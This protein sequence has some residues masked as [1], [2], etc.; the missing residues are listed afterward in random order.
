V[1]STGTGKSTL[2][3]FCTGEPVDTSNKSDECTKEIQAVK[4]ETGLVWVDTVGFDGTDTNRTDEEAFQEILQ[5]LQ[6]QNISGVAAVIWTV[7]PEIRETGSLQKQANL[8]DKFKE[9]GA[10]SNVIIVVKNTRGNIE[11][12]AAGA[13]AACNNENVKTIGYSLLD[14]LKDNEKVFW[15]KQT[16]EDRTN[17][18]ILTQVEAKLLIKNTLKTLPPSKQVVFSNHKCESCG[19]VGDPRL[20]P[21]SCHT[22]R[23]AVHPAASVPEHRGSTTLIHPAARARRHT[24]GVDF[25][26]S[27]SKSRF[28]GGS[29]SQGPAFMAC[30]YNNP[31]HPGCQLYY[32]CCNQIQGTD[33]GPEEY[34]VNLGLPSI[35]GNIGK[36]MQDK[37]LAELATRHHTQTKGCKK[38]YK[39]CGTEAS[40]SNTGCGRTYPCCGGSEGS[41]GC[42][43]Q[44]SHCKVAWGHFDRDKGC[45]GTSHDNVNI[46]E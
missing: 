4:D 33:F 9:G 1:G 12:D 26:T 43:Q 18:G 22:R 23:E 6:D 8:I 40:Q 24:E 35:F 14:Q 29:V 32:P 41:D 2:V 27:S 38:I 5:F 42:R 15:E 11:K 13:R 25:I 17:M 16:R 46:V 28:R 39:C 31:N 10:W 19:V 30:C 34:L 44:C 7:N 20:F 3:G 21:L 45:M 37:K 36:Q